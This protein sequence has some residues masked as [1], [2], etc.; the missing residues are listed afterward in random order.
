M[1]RKDPARDAVPVPWNGKRAMPDSRRT[2]YRAEDGGRNRAHQE[3]SDQAWTLHQFG[4]RHVAA[5]SGTFENHAGYLPAAA[6]GLKSAA[7]DP[8]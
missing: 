2:E 5:G 3:S 7:H 1:W 4:S 8:I 6:A